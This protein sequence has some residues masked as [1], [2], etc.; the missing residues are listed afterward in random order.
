MK[1][2]VD[3]DAEI[4]KADKKLDFARL[5]LSKV[6]KTESHPDYAETVPENV[7]LVNEEKVQIMYSLKFMDANNCRAEED[8]GSGNSNVG[9]IQGDIHGTEMRNQRA[10]PP[11]CI[12]AVSTSLES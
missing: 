4:A 8:V 6:V 3:L 1:G 11:N 5:N 2:L 10:D 7:R 9:V 12:R